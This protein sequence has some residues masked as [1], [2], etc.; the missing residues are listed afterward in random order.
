MSAVDK[1]ETFFSRSISDLI[2]KYEGVL[3]N[4]E[5]GP[6]GPVINLMDDLHN[7]ALDM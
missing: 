2:C 3:S 1:L 7:V 4:K 6:Q 5:A